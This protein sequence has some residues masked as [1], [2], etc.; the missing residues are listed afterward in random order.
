MNIQDCAEHAKRSIKEAGQRLSAPLKLYDV[1][2]DF[3]DKRLI[4][5]P[6]HRYCD[7]AAVGRVIFNV[8]AVAGAHNRQTVSSGVLSFY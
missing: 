3:G 5:A 1:K 7:G 6:L 2:Y 8:P 4:E